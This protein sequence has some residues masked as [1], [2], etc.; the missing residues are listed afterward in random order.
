[1]P[2]V[3]RTEGVLFGQPA[4]AL[5]SRERAEGL[6]RVAEMNQHTARRDYVRARAAI[7]LA[8]R[9]SRPASRWDRGEVYAAEQVRARRSTAFRAFNR[10]LAALRAADRDVAAA[11]VAVAH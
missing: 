8:N 6:L 3:P 4:A 5:T 2:F 11:R 7:G 9:T 10:A 1:M